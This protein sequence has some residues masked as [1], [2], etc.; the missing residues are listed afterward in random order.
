MVKDPFR[1]WYRVYTYCTLLVDLGYTIHGEEHKI[2]QPKYHGINY[3]I[4][5]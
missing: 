3:E 2:K 4:K 1:K 5:F